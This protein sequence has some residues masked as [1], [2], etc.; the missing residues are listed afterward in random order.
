MRR[1]YAVVLSALVLLAGGLAGCGERT[2]E[3]RAEAPAAWEGGRIDS[4]S[5][6]ADP[7]LTVTIFPGG[8]AAVENAPEG[9]WVKTESGI[10]V[11][12]TDGVYSGPAK[13]SWFHDT[14][15]Q[16]EYDDSAVIFWA[17]PGRFGS[18]DW[19]E[20]KAVACRGERTWGLGLSCGTS[21]TR[22]QPPCEARE[23]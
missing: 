9:Q 4:D 23:E 3:S 17:W 2:P 20:L 7:R 5:S 19:A 14:G 18:Y 11:D 16:L 22:E 8:A 21:G 10:C 1:R 6:P 13:W 12:A 15:L